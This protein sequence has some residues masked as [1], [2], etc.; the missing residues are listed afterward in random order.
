[1]IGS[2]TCRPGSAVPVTLPKRVTAQDSVASTWTATEA[3]TKSAITT[4]TTISPMRSPRMGGK[5][6]RDG[7]TTGRFRIE[8]PLLLIPHPIQAYAGRRAYG[9]A[10]LPI[11][12][13]R[14]TRGC[15]Y[16]RDRF[17]AGR[18]ESVRHAERHH[19]KMDVR[20]TKW[21]QIARCKVL[22]AASFTLP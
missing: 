14:L 11:V 8:S 13:Q 20:T 16:A 18:V 2:L 7:S 12:L 6:S 15:G 21:S 4:A 10:R 17:G 5:S 1:M 19:I 22:A 3:S 9:S